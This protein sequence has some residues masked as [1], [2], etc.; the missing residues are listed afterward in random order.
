MRQQIARND[1]IRLV[2][3]VHSD[4]DL[5]GHL[6]HTL[7]RAISAS[8]GLDHFIEEATRPDDFKPPDLSDPEFPSESS[9]DQETTPGNRED[10][11]VVAESAS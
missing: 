6:D 11:A 10:A 7:K 5:L 1:Q 4:I 2:F 9:M 8:V 3:Q